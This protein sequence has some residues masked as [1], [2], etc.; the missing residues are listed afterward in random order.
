MRP[1]A[2]LSGRPWSSVCVGRAEKLGQ[3]VGGN[4]NLVVRRGHNTAQSRRHGTT[5]HGW[6]GSACSADWQ[7]PRAQEAKAGELGGG[8]GGG[9]GN[10]SCGAFVLLGKGVPSWS[11]ANRVG[12]PRWGR[13]GGGWCWRAGERA[14]CRVPGMY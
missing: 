7:L 9:E 13:A 11:G 12:S 2:P 6:Q 10:M 4:G 14:A 3:A 8:G 5:P 1:R